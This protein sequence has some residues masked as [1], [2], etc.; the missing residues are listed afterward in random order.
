MI[1]IYQVEMHGKWA[2]GM[3]IVSAENEY[4]AMNIANALDL[5]NVYAKSA[6]EIPELRMLKKEKKVLAQFSLSE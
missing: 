2:G 3:V 5:Y 4:E 6:T 1:K